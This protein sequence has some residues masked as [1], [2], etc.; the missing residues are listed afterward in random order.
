MNPMEYILFFGLVLF[1]FFV[2]GLFVW[3][4]WELLTVTARSKKEYKDQKK[5]LSLSRNPQNPLLHPTTYDFEGQAVMNPAAIHDGEQTHLF[6]RAIGNDGVSRIGYANSKD[7]I[8]IDERLPYPVF[9]LEG[10]DPHLNTMRRL[11]AEKNYPALVASGGSWGGTEDPRAVVIDD[12]AYLSFSAFHNWDSVRMGMTSIALDDLKNKRWKW[13]PVTFL[14]PEKQVHKNWLLFPQKLFGKFAVMHSISPDVEVEYRDD[15]L[16][17]GKAT[18]YIHSTEGPRIAL[19]NTKAG[20]WHD[21]MRGPGVPPIK[22]D[23]GWLLFYHAMQKHEPSK[24]KLGAMMLDHDDPTKII[25]RSPTPVLEPEAHY[26]TNGAKPGIVYA[27]GATTHND[28]LTLY[29]GASDNFVC[30][31]SAPLKEFVD[32]LMHHGVPNLKPK[33]V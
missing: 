10:P 29:Y 12:R 31:A 22:T 19:V 27:S 32:K 26:E 3:G 20:F 15:I 24:Y 16:A 4:V 11:Y 25:A 2:S 8:T 28:K 14:S 33:I 21:R 5:A 9:A 30:S 17:T 23:A 1:A 18:P 7:G 13:S 6:Y